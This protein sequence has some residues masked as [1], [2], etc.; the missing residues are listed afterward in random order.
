MTVVI[1][2]TRIHRLYVQCTNK[3]LLL[4]DTCYL[5]SACIHMVLTLNIDDI[6][7]IGRI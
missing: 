4:G 5:R 2:G 3:L 1:L 7:N 6:E